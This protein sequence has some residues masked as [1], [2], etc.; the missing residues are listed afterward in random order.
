MQFLPQDKVVEFARMDGRE[1][2]IATEKASVNYLHCGTGQGRLLIAFFPFL[3][4]FAL[5]HKT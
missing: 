3:L 1:L 4:W 2:L 5:S